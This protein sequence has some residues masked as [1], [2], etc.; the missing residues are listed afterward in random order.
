MF[1]S[2]QMSHLYLQAMDLWHF[3]G[4]YLMPCLFCYH[5]LQDLDRIGLGN[6]SRGCRCAMGIAAG[7]VRCAIRIALGRVA[8][9][10]PCLGPGPRSASTGGSWSAREGRAKQHRRQEREIQRDVLTRSSAWLVTPYAQ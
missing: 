9:V 2:F 8:C 10:P 4:I 1:V 3:G 7:R 5:F 6:R